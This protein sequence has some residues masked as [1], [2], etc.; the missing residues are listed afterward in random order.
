MLRK[1][2]GYSV[3]L[4]VV[5]IMSCVTDALCHTQLL[6]SFYLRTCDMMSLHEDLFGPHE[7]QILL[8]LHFITNQY[9]QFPKRYC[10]FVTDNLFVIGSAKY[11]SV[12]IFPT[13]SVSAAT[14][15]CTA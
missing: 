3:I 14:A 15:H 4:Y 5:C 8:L 9:V 11:L 6:F 1:R 12:S 7:L 13:H 2:V 10:L